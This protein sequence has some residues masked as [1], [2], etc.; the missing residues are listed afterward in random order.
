MFGNLGKE[1]VH[2]S[3]DSSFE[4]KSFFVPLTTIKVIYIIVIVGFIAFFSNFFNGFV[5][6]D[7]WYIINNVQ[8]HKISIVHAFGENIFNNAGQY[9][10]LQPLYFSLVY[11]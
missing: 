1:L 2:V 8:I 11:N 7:K 4:L 10:P 3:E 5:G 6:D 9:R